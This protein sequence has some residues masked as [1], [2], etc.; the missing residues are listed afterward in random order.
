MKREVCTKMKINTVNYLIGDAF[1]SLK[2]NRTICIASIITVFITIVNHWYRFPKKYYG[3]CIKNQSFFV[4][5][6]EN[7]L[8]RKRKML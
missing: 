4:N 2:R 5:L 1:K 6:A 7:S 3:F 8:D